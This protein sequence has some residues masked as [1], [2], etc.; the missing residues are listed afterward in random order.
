M[1]EQKGKARSNLSFYRQTLVWMTTD[2]ALLVDPQVRCVTTF[3]GLAP[4]SHGN[5]QVYSKPN[6]PNYQVSSSAALQL[7]GPRHSAR[8]PHGRRARSPPGG[9]SDRL[10]DS[11]QGAKGTTRH[12]NMKFINHR[13]LTPSGRVSRMVALPVTKQVSTT[14]RQHP[15]AGTRYS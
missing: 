8:T 7:P 2:E 4:G 9:N 12:I 13:W 5:S 1:P 10:L 14:R 11:T 3:A 6:Y 15:P